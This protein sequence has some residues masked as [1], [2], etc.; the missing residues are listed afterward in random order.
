MRWVEIDKGVVGREWRRK[1]GPARLHG[2]C[3]RH[4]LRRHLSS[5]PRSFWEISGD[6]TVSIQ[7]K[8]VLLGIC[9]FHV[10]KAC[11]GRISLDMTFFY[12]CL[13]NFGAE[14]A[15]FRGAHSAVHW[16][17]HHSSGVAV[18]WAIPHNL[19]A[20]C[21]FWLGHAVS[22]LTIQSCAF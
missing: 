1:R 16:L 18:S 17:L 6:Q 13:L 21:P 12:P 5:R 8:L 10:Q 3:S 14:D 15:R 4:S 9:S 7:R 11:C 19:I 20:I 2:L 22:A